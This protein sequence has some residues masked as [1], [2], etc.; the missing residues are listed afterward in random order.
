MAS[1]APDRQMQVST[2]AD[3][4][5]AHD[6]PPPDLTAFMETEIQRLKAELRRAQDANREI[7]DKNRQL[8]GNKK[9]QIQ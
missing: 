8:A 7:L 6:A 4:N 3:A 2:D 5:V 1:A 9:F